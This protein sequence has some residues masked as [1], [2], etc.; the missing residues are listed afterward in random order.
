MV[1]SSGDISSKMDI[2]FEKTFKAATSS[3]EISVRQVT[4]DADITT[5]SGGIL[6]ENIQGNA[7]VAASSG[8]VRIQRIDGDVTAG[9]SSGDIEIYDGSGMR[10]VRTTSGEIVLEHVAAV[11]EA[12]S[13]SG[14]V[15]IKAQEGSGS[16]HTTSGDIRLDLD[17]L[18]GNLTLESSSGL[19]KIRISQDNAFDFKADTSSGEIATFFDDKLDFS[20]KGNSAKGVYGSKDTGNRV[21]VRT[22]S[23]DVQVVN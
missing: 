16:I 8:D 20:K 18:T 17:K 4:G 21:V 6:S 10:T 11:W 2:A 12:E 5:T 23:G 19:A 13:S 14:D 7:H 1:T 22:T 15:T 9:S 3:G